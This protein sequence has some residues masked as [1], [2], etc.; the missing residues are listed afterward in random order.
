MPRAPLLLLATLLVGAYA[1]RPGKEHAT[2][3]G[4]A[5]SDAHSDDA[6]SDT[7]SALSEDDEDP[8]ED[9]L[10]PFHGGYEAWCKHRE[11]LSRTAGG[12]CS[13]DGAQLGRPPKPENEV[14]EDAFALAVWQ[15]DSET[16]LLQAFGMSS[17]QAVKRTK[18]R[19]NLVWVGTGG[20]RPALPTLEDLDA[21]W[22]AAPCTRT[23]D[24]AMSLGVGIR[25]LQLHFEKLGFS[26]KV[27]P[28]DG[29][30][31]EA[32]EAISSRG[33]CSN[34]GVSFAWGELRT[35]FGIYAT[36]HQ[37]RRCLK[38][39]D[40]EGVRRRAWEAAKTKFVY[41]VPGPRSL[42]HIDAHE[43]LAKI[44][45]IWIHICVD[46]YSRFIVYLKV[47]T[48]KYAETV[49]QIFM[50][51][52]EQPHPGDPS[53]RMWASRIRGDKGSENKG[54]VEE[55]VFRMGEGRGS[56]ILGR[57]V[58]NCRAEYMW[59]RVKRHVTGYFR[60][61]FFNMQERGLLDPNSPSDLHCLQA[62]YVG[63]VQE[64]CDDFC[65][66]WNNH[67]IRGR[68]T[69]AGHG[70]GIP[71]ELF[72]DPVAS[73]AVDHDDALT[74][75]ELETYGVDEPIRG[76]DTEE[77]VTFMSQHVVDPLGD[78][79]H[80]QAIRTA[81]FQREPL[82]TA[83]DG[84]DDYLRYRSVCAELLEAVLRHRDATFV[85]DWK[86]FGTTPSD[87]PQVEARRLR[88]KLAW[89]AVGVEPPEEAGEEGEDGGEASEGGG[90][91]EAE[92]MD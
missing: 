62:I 46:G 17:I 88:Q 79:P 23:I 73:E 25:T 33:W 91:G 45:G 76:D 42:Y 26:P 22:E 35:H 40:P 61:L 49:R 81:Y 92:P 24:L 18:K 63:Q 36:Y 75:Q 39:L 55:Q 2:D 10:H 82:S 67:R 1:P 38:T 78:W 30:V 37:I 47:S 57:S 56:A 89:V 5:H 77:E 44:W 15:G 80:L 43:K 74:E 13:A 85:V 11:E 59:A 29:P 58:Q 50:E 27:A 64:A 16:D 7:A 68:R 19:L 65:R 51:A 66:I 9:G 28:D 72:L 34:L 84:V 31:L 71:A 20:E 8:D 90:E 52:M 69:E 21:L 53:R 87:D 41:S 54:W 86:A 14:D 6:H 48:D 3:G 4:Q 32:L 12:S 70:G 60:E 83:S